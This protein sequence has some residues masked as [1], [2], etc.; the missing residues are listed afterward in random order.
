M[1]DARGKKAKKKEAER[2]LQAVKCSQP[3]YIAYGLTWSCLTQHWWC[4]AERL[5]RREP[6]SYSSSA[7][8]VHVFYS[9]LSAH[10]PS[11]P[12]QKHFVK[13]VCLLPNSQRYRPLRRLWPGVFMGTP[14][15]PGS[16]LSWELPGVCPF[17]KLQRLFFFSPSLRSSWESAPGKVL[18]QTRWRE[19]PTQVDGAYYTN[20]KLFHFLHLRQAE[21]NIHPTCTQ[22]FHFASWL[23]RKLTFQKIYISVSVYIYCMFGDSPYPQTSN[24]TSAE[25]TQRLRGTLFSLRCIIWFFFH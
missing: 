11:S 8:N 15:N 6:R 10:F 17:S 19:D 14:A 20:P 9:C 23:C 22:S 18:L 21:G 13:S 2:S 24:V 7:G 16:Q 5:Q 12:I 4:T 1:G 25:I 3:Q